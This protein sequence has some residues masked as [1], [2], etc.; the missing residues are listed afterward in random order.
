MLEHACSDSVVKRDA[1]KVL[2]E[3]TVECVENTVSK[4][5]ELNNQDSERG[6]DIETK[7]SENRKQFQEMVESA[8]STLVSIVD[9]S[10]AETLA[11]MKE[12][13]K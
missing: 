12:I 8:K 6:T 2:F 9:T 3:K 5:E 13:S 7:L 10:L 4:L 1:T 11:E